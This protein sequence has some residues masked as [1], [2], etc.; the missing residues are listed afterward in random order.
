[1]GLSFSRMTQY[2]TE[3]LENRLSYARKNIYSLAMRV[4]LANQLVGNACWYMLQ[5]WLGKKEVFEKFDKKFNDFVW[6]GKE[7]G[8][9]P[10]VDYATILK[11]KDQG[12]LGFIS[13]KVQ[14]TA[15]VG[16]AIMWAAQDGDKNL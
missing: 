1:M 6:S 13:F 14:T 11:P 16:K 4:T 2:L 9:R 10:C 8:K 7:L 12:G 5:I 15:M 3:T